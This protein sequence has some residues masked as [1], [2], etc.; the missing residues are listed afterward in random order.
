MKKK[1]KVIPAAAKGTKVRR[2]LASSVAL[3]AL[4]KNASKEFRLAV[5]R[6]MKQ[7]AVAIK[8]LAGR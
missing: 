4:E 8:N 6:A 3:E 2:Q 7:Y 1:A 5:N